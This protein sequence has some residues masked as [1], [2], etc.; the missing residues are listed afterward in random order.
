MELFGIIE[1]LRYRKFLTSKLP[2]VS[3]KVINEV[4]I[5]KLPPTCLLKVCDTS[6]A[7][8]KWVSPKR[9]RSY[10]YARVYDTINACATKVVAVIPIVKD[11]GVR[12]DRDFLQWDTVS[13]MSLLNV[14]VIPAYYCDAERSNK[15]GKITNQ[16]FDKDYVNGKL[17]ELADYCA[18]ALHWNLKELS[19][20]NLNKLM[21]KVIACYEKISQETGV[22]MHPRDGLIEF[23]NRIEKGLLCMKTLS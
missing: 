1:N 7:L 2:L 16:R 19:K 22:N 21:K 12:G 14:Y 5:N 13:L 18:S 17:Q 4:D 8:S 11:E 23:K 6:F 9:T 10:P 15:P 20:K 3:A